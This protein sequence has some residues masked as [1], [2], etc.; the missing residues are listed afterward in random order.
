MNALFKNTINVQGL[1]CDHANFSFL[2]ANFLCVNHVPRYQIVIDSLL[3]L[4]FSSEDNYV[5]KHSD[6]GIR[7]SF[8]TEDLVTGNKPL[9]FY[10]LIDEKHEPWNYQAESLDN[11]KDAI[12]WTLNGRL[13]SFGEFGM[14]Y[15]FP[16]V[17]AK[18]AKTN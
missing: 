12:F 8:S 4:G 3:E 15:L 2:S 1:P 7:I 10:D 11:F 16:T 13:D 18:L 6:L 14:D 17:Q 9:E 5:F